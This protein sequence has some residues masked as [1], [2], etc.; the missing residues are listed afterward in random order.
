MNRPCRALLALLSVLLLLPRAARADDPH[1]S[2][3][4]GARGIYYRPKDA[5]RG[6]WGEGVQYKG[7]MGEALAFQASVDY[8]RH[9]ASGANYRT[10]P[11]QISLLG[12][13][14]PTS[15]LAPFLIAG[16]GWY[17]TH[18][19]GPGSHTERLLRP[20]IG[21]GIEILASDKIS[22]DASYRFLW[23]QVYRFTDFGHPYGSNFKGQGSMI[24]LALNYRF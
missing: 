24:T 6:A 18:V 23:S 20:H 13:F 17:F 19:D 10:I 7:P 12:Y 5:D 2:P 22:L 21:A 11:A 8:V 15:P 14:T 16:L 9:S 1:T 4:V 3:T